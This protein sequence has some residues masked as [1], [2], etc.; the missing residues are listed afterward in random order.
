MVLIFLCLDDAFDL[1]WWSFIVYYKSRACTFLNGEKVLQ[2]TPQ[3]LKKC[4]CDFNKLVLNKILSLVAFNC[5]NLSLTAK[6]TS[7]K[8]IVE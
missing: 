8:F 5:I 2:K 4:K 6:Y 1:M 3:I 7:E